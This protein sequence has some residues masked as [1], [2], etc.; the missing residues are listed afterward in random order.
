[1]QHNAAHQLH[2][3]RAH[4]QH[5]VGGFAGGGEGFG[6]DVVQRF[7]VGQ[8]LLELRGLGLQLRIG[9]GAVVI[10]QRLDLVH[11]GID[12]LQLALTVSTENFGNQSHVIATS[13]LRL[14]K[15]LSFHII[16]PI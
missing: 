15:N 11:N 6:Q 10:L 5:A 2:T 8:T 12:A 7:A 4:A 14:K 16:N 13:F 1:M 9:H 3:V